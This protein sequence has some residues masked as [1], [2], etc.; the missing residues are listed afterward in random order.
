MDNNSD[1][2]TENNNLNYA[3]A[4]CELYVTFEQFFKKET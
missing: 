4:R 1:K 2:F 3:Q